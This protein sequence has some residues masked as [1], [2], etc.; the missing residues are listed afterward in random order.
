MKASAVAAG[1]QP[2]PVRLGND[3]LFGAGAYAGYH[4]HLDAYG[5]LAA[6]LTG[7]GLIGNW[8]LPA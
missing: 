2:A 8:K 4:N 5:P 6:H 7:P 3:R 1:P